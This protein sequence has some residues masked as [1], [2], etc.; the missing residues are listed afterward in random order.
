M[1]FVVCSYTVLEGENSMQHYRHQENPNLSAKVW[2]EL[3]M[4][5]M[6]QQAEFNAPF[7]AQESQIITEKR[8]SEPT[9]IFAKNLLGQDKTDIL[10]I[11]EVTKKINLLRLMM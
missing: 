4:A 6:K 3:I 11:E 7:S 10:M 8:S 9:I 2:Y 5:K 1:S